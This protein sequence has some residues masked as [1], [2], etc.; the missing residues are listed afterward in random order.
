MKLITSLLPLVLTFSLVDSVWAQWDYGQH[1]IDNMIEHRIDMRKT[2]ARM[3][4]RRKGSTKSR[5]KNAKNTRARSRRI[6]TSIRKKVVSLPSNVSFHRDSYQNFHLDDSKGY[7]V[8]FLFASA[9]GK[10]IR[11]SYNFTYYNSGTDFKDIPIEKYKVTAQGVYG[12]KKYPVHLG[13]EDGDSMNPL[14]G[15]FAPSIAIEVKAGKDQWGDATLLT[16]PSTLLVR[17][18]E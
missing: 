17:V 8:N 12:G 15:N 3:E 2:R 11:K 6:S 13:S 9:S 4:A 7:T 18:I 16:L 10:V 1:S 14:G 5:R